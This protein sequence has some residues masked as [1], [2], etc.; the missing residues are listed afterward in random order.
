MFAMLSTIAMA[1]HMKYN[2]R[3]MISMTSTDIPPTQKLQKIEQI[4]LNSQYL[5]YPLKDELDNDE[6]YLSH[7]AVI[8]MKYHGSYMQD[9]RDNRQKGVD[10]E[11]SFMLRLKSPAGEIPPELYLKLD[12]MCDE[13]G[14][15][16][17][18]ATTRQAYQMHGIIKGNLKTVI[19]NI[20][21][22]T[23]STI[24][25]C[26]DVSRNVMTTPAP[27][28]TPEYIYT[29]HY[30]KI[31][32]ELFKP[33]SSIVTELWENDEKITTIDYWL[34]D[35]KQFDPELDIKKELLHDTGRGVILSDPIEPL[36]GI[37]Y[38]PK[39]FKIA[40]TV[41]EDNSLDIYTNDIGLV[42]IVDKESGNN[43]LL[44]FNV[45]VGGGMGRTHN[46]DATFA[47]TGDHLGF[48]PKDDIIEVCKCIIAAQR[49]HGNREIRTN[50]RMKYLVHNLGINKFR[51][52][53]ETYYGKEILPW[54]EIPSWKY[55]DWMGWY[56]QGDGK[57]FLGI[58]IEQGRIRDYNDHDNHMNFMGN[59]KNL[60]V[61][62]AIR[63]IVTEFKLTMILTPSQSIIF[64]DILS[65][66]VNKI[67]NILLKYNMKSIENI[68]T[69]IRHSM[70][71]PALPLCG[72]AVTEAERRMPE[73]LLNMRNIMNKIGLDN[74]ESMIIRMTGCPNGCARPYMAELSLVGDGPEM[75]QI[76]VGG[77][78]ILTNVGFIYK[79]K[80]KWNDINQQIEPLFLYY[81]I[82]R[83]DNN[84]SFGT[85]CSR[86]GINEL[87][88][89][90]N[91][92]LTLNSK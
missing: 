56:D 62:T 79:N 4:K 53:I 58:N 74:N 28:T 51:N 52:L 26:G 61:R 6:V 41:P 14:Q 87:L 36:Y 16:D 76:W 55:N 2:R 19:N 70:A 85:F 33:Q 49:D 69:L 92:Y 30:A 81:K 77:S 50:S 24:G 32:A 9:N 72:L 73:F 42:T 67:N 17:L 22:S 71:C 86:I 21:L 13:Y 39:K 63:E 90:S 40:I 34:K 48:V 10:K 91:T 57:K 47:R 38:L 29:R 1:L 3:Y 11:Y 84:E 80:V 45:I 66:D 75:Y 68:D 12:E 35:V 31:L 20:M 83:Y 27:F 59:L 8:V 82:N 37:R 7:D 64:K 18:R 5:T 78:P 44:G 25:A 54:K 23:S 88:R 60:K 65:D 46:K 15:N 89:F 43:E